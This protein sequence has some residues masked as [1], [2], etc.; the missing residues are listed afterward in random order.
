MNKLFFH[1]P[2]YVLLCSVITSPAMGQEQ[3]K[4]D[5][6]KVTAARIEQSLKDVNMSVSV[7]TADQIKHSNAKSVGEILQ[8]VSGVRINNDG[9]QGIKRVEIRGESTFRTVV[10]ID[11][12]RVAEHKSMSGSPF[13][14]SPADIERIEVIK[15]PA[16]VFYGSDALGGVVNIIT[17][18][19]GDKPFEADATFGYNGSSAGTNGS[20]GIRGNLN[21]WKYR[22]SG[23]YE[24]NNALRTPKGHAPNSYY[25]SRNVGG[26]LSYDFN[27]DWTAGVNLDYYRFKFG[28][29]NYEMGD[30]FAVDVPKWERTK[31]GVFTEGRNITD[32]FTK[33]RADGFY[34]KNKKDMANMVRTPKITMNPLA[35]NDLDQYGFSVQ[36]D[37][38]I[39]GF[40]TLV[41]GYEFNYDKLNADSITKMQPAGVPLQIIVKNDNYDG[42]QMNNALFASMETYLPADFTLNY[43]VRYTWVK[44]HMDISSRLKGTSQNPGNSSDSKAVFNGGLTWTGID[45]LTLRANYSQGYKFP[46]LQHLYIDT[47]MGSTGTTFSNPDLKPE[48]SDNFEIGARWLRNGF[49]F[50]TALFYNSADNYIAALYNKGLGDY[51]YQNVAKAKTWGLEI[52][53]SWKIGETGFEP[54]VFFTWMR[55]QFQENGMKTFDTATPEI[56]TRYGLKWTGNIKDV[57]LRT[58]VYARTQ[59]AIKYKDLE[60]TTNN[61]RLGGSTTFNATA[62]IDFG[63]KKQY[64][65]DMG[66]YNIFDKTWRNEKS[67]YEPRRYFAAKINA[68]F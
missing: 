21:G 36:A 23:G 9:G 30:N 48:T 29:G 24:H 25:D 35:Y 49:K 40:N 7:V 17:K 28:S 34:Q 32:W 46:I 6:V 64:S 58:D 2:L 45:D 18:K 61:Y 22:I 1:T 42:Y 20:I 19:G 60:D 67:I 59:S 41:T 12:Q 5:E 38:L 68:S 37:W 65:F 51:Q 33:I 14:V 26:A 10:L 39:A 31:V 13:M 8:D 15:G 27:K 56:F 55:R 43:G 11:G 53:S 63:P 57:R 62:G 44:S 4:A 50:D 66:L 52:D 16:S 47:S 54:Y 3:V